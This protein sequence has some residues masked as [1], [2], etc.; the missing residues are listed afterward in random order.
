MAR[1]KEAV[2]DTVGQGQV[3]H[4]ETE[5]GK[6]KMPRSS[7]GEQQRRLEGLSQDK[8]ATSPAELAP[9]LARNGIL[10]QVPGD[11]SCC[12]EMPGKDISWDGDTSD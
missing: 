6:E 8:T 11:G 2:K 3:G 4:Q 7:Q 10:Q 9:E 1:G 5:A 12:S